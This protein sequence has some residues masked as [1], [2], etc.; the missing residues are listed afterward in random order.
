M[1]SPTGKWVP[2]MSK[3]RAE[4]SGL[5]A[6]AAI[7]GVSKSLVKAETTVANAAPITT[8]TAM[9]TTLPRRMNCL[10]PLSMVGLQSGQS[11]AIGAGGQVEIRGRDARATPSSDSH[12]HYDVAVLVVFALGGAELAGG[13]W[14]FQLQADVAGACGLEE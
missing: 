13:L 6:M 4:K 5:P 2:P 7:S 1:K 9:S 14:V 8:P 12:R 11:S 3:P 10:N